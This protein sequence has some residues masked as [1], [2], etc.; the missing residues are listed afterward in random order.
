MA[1]FH[2]VEDYQKHINNLIQNHDIDTAMSL[3]VGGGG[4]R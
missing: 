1:N 2:F 3:A 4:V